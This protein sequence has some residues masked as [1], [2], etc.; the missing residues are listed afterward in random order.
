[1]LT[2]QELKFCNFLW[3][4][5]GFFFITSY[6]GNPL[7]STETF[8]G[9]SINVMGKA[10][11]LSGADRGFQI[12][13]LVTVWALSGASLNCSLLICRAGSG[14]V[15]VRKQTHV[16]PWEDAR[17]NWEDAYACCTVPVSCLGDSKWNWELFL[18]DRIVSV[19]EDQTLNDQLVIYIN[20]ILLFSS[21][22]SKLYFLWKFQI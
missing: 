10:P 21:L 4:S 11:G 9:A 16:R 3:S 15:K 17:I 6:L 12:Q 20:S 8:K 13:A 7:C 14:G 19:Q 2:L 18:L 22:Q 1:M 5:L